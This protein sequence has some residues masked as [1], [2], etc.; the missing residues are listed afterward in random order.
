MNTNFLKL[1]NEKTQQYESVIDVYGVMEHFG[2]TDS[3]IRSTNALRRS[4]SNMRNPFP[5]PVKIVGR[6]YW[7]YNEI[8]QWQLTEACYLQKRLDGLCELEKICKKS[9]DLWK[10]IYKQDM[11]ECGIS[12]G[13]L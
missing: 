8:R 6:N 2:I 12:V 4:R 7:F 5:V 10:R 9:A 13:E 3:K 1:F 11:K